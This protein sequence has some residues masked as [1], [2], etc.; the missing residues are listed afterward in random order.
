MSNNN[1][2]NFEKKLSSSQILLIIMGTIFLAG[3]L[4]MK[5]SGILVL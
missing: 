5:L 3:I 4:V 1:P 2:R